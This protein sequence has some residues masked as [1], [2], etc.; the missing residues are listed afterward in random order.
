MKKHPALILLAL[1]V[2]LA[3]ALSA[4]DAPKPA[5]TAPA[6]VPATSATPKHRPPSGGMRH[7]GPRGGG[8]WHS[9]KNG[10]LPPNLYRYFQKLR[11]E[12]PA[13]YERLQRLRAENREAFMAEVARLFPDP[14]R[15]FMARTRENERKCWEIVRQLR[16]N[17]PPAN[18]KELQEQ[19][20]ALVNASYELLV[21]HS[22][23]RI[24]ALQKRLQEIQANR[25]TIV[26]QRLQFYLNAPT[27]PPKN[28]PPR[29]PD[30]KK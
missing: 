19:L 18:A 16:A 15:D 21:E 6:A 28:K 10:S 25:E 17:P 22:Q 4:E 11:E 1:L 2:L 26:K 23:K 30:E 20:N 13:E 14:D 12:N 7:G 24:E 27:P 8:H 29:R 3:Q 5:T 9:P